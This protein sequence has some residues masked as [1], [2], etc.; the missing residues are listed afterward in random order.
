[1]NRTI[2]EEIIN[3]WDPIGLFP[4]SPKDEYSSELDSI[5]KFLKG[6]SD[7]ELLANHIYEIFVRNFGEDVFEKS[8]ADCALI[9]KKLMEKRL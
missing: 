7:N 8:K 9:A 5:S 3:N 4:F 1:M 6:N 2:V